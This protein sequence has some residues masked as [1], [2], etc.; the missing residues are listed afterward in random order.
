MSEVEKD[1]GDRAKEEP[2]LSSDKNGNASQLI[3]A[4]IWIFI[5]TGFSIV[6]SV[7]YVFGLSV[8]LH[9]DFRSYFST[10]DYLEV[11]PYWLGGPVVIV[12][13]F[14]VILYVT[15]YLKDKDIFEFRLTPEPGQTWMPWLHT[16][17]GR[18]V[19]VS[20]MFVVVLFY[21]INPFPGFIVIVQTFFTYLLLDIILNTKVVREGIGSSLIAIRRR[22]FFFWQGVK[23]LLTT[24]V[25]AVLLGMIWE[26]RGLLDKPISAIYLAGSNVVV[27]GR[28]LFSLTQYLMAM[29]EDGT[30]VAIP[31][32]KVDRIETSRNQNIGSKSAPTPTPIQRAWPTPLSMPT[33]TPNAHLS[34]RA[35]TSLP[36]SASPVPGLS[37][38]PTPT[39][40]PSP[41]T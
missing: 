32:A 35:E 22:P 23:F 3:N 38:V 6:T 28:I 21:F 10:K 7:F 24:G 13:F 19:W 40:A 11:T 41:K 2:G 30:V 14:M 37:P 34:P 16:R 17:V 8:G 39:L 36:P 4:A 1:A 5:V 9:F 15:K 12:I 25:Y 26:P 27:Q 20:I 18:I 29:R 31:V 33:P